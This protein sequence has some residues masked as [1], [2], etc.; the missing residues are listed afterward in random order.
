MCVEVI[1]FKGNIKCLYYDGTNKHTIV[2][3]EK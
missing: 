3:I 2:K 1:K